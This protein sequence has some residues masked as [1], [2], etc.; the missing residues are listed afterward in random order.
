MVIPAGTYD[1]RILENETA[2]L[3]LMVEDATFE[4]GVFYDMI[5]LPDASGLSVDPVLIPYF[6]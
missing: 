6:P 2:I 3:V 1:V 5:I 4:P